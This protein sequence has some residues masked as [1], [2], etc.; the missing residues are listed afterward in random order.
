MSALSTTTGHDFWQRW[1][2]SQADFTH[3]ISRPPDL[4]PACPST[5]CV[6]VGRWFATR[7]VYVCKDAITPSA[8]DPSSLWRVLVRGNLASIG[9]HGQDPG[10]RQSQHSDGSGQPSSPAAPRPPKPRPPVV[11]GTRGGAVRAEDEAEEDIPDCTESRAGKDTKS[12][13]DLPCE[14]VLCLGCEARSHGLVRGTEFRSASVIASWT[15]RTDEN[16]IIF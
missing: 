6:A 5:R 1:A 15:T 13:L 12:R 3:C 2:E 10:P 8:H 9:S 16:K 4:G 11:V 14:L 7:S